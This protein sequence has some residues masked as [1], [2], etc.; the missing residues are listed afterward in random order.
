[1]GS[2]GAEKVIYGLD[3]VEKFERLVTKFEPEGKLMRAWRLEGGVSAQVTALEIEQAEG[4][5]RK[6]IVRQYG[7]NDLSHNPQV[8]ADEFKLLEILHANTVLVPQPFYLDQALE[9]FPTPYIVIEFIEGNTEFAPANLTYF[10]QQMATQLA[11]IHSLDCSKLDLAFLPQHTEMFATKL[12]VR[13]AKLD[14]SLQEGLIRSILAKA[15]P[16]PPG[17]KPVILHGDYWMGNILWRDGEITAIIDW[18]DAQVGDPLADVANARLEILW[19]FGLA[20]METFT[21]YYRSLA[22]ID[23]H[24][25]PYWDLVAA[26]RPAAKLSTWGLNPD[27]EKLFRERH[28]LFVSRAIAELANL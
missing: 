8:A 13:S 9:I 17:N 22:A 18:E 14:E 28:K 4:Y 16:L 26:L 25:L 20:A 10:L 24:S 11:K 7:E 6:L 21:G 2:V 1:L 5:T 12:K 19:A 15:F 27:T 23:Y 3:L